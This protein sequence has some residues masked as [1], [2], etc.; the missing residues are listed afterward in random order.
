MND[1]LFSEVVQTVNLWWSKICV[2]IFGAKIVAL[3]S[4]Q[5]ATKAKFTDMISYKT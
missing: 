1:T 2:M 4:E 3:S 5:G